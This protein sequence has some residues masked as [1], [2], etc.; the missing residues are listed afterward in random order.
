MKSST[1]VLAIDVGAE[2]GRVM[3]AKFDGASIS[4]QELHRF[5]NGPVEIRGTLYWDF[6]RLWA[7]IQIG[8]QKSLAQ[9]PVSLGVDTWGVDFALLD[10]DGNLLCNPVHYRDDRTI[11]MPERVF[12]QA[13]RDEVFAR[14]GIQM[15]RINTLY[16]VMS[17]VEAGSPLLGAAETFLTAP[18]LL[19]FWFSGEKVSEFTIASTTQMV[20]IS[21][22]FWATDLLDRLNIPSKIFPEIVP[23]G[24]SLGQYGD[25]TV[26]APACHDTGSAV[27]ALPAV[28]GGSFAYISSGT[29]SLI[30]LELDE[31][32]VNE[33]VAAANITNEGGV[34]GTT[35]F[36]SNVVGLWLVQQCR[37]T[38]RDEGRQYDYGSLVHLAEQE[39]ALAA[40]I[41][42]TDSDFVMPGDHPSLV[43]EQ[44]R[45]TNQP[46]PQNDG[47]VIRCVLESLA[48]E[49]RTVIER[50]VALTGRP[51]ETIHIVGGGSQNRL[52]CQMTADATGRE[53]VAGPVEAT[54]LGNAL[55]Q[56]I[57]LGELADLDEG[58][59]VVAAMSELLRYV[60]QDSEVWDQ[61]YERY[62]AIKMIRAQAD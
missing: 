50:L 7:E 41:D 45:Q 59:Q 51:V 33:D 11:G 48:L 34:Y 60:P 55:I 25:L 13:P 14:T 47:Q 56:L 4:V 22:G 6:L 62:Q 35:R 10:R 21:T 17:L 16:Q 20:D 9:K 26:I 57:T 36:L 49:Y 3:A 2:S 30:G 61:A 38:W 24:T 44:C 8:V 23:P 37:S 1:Q 52:L 54:V 19:N 42:P 46:V 53:V 58:R 29:W 18:D 32:L 15:M 31:P 43:R 12:S 5:P 28:K 39:P 40:F 27:A